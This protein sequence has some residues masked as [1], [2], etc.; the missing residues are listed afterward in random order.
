MS[1]GSGGS[2]LLQRS[3][4][5]SFDLTGCGDLVVTSFRSGALPTV[6]EEVE[7]A[8]LLVGLGRTFTADS[9]VTLDM[10]VRPLWQDDRSS[11]GFSSEEVDRDEDDDAACWPRPRPRR[12]ECPTALLAGLC[13]DLSGGL[14][15]ARAEGIR[16]P[17]LE[18]GHQLRLTA[19]WVDLDR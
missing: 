17:W 10:D 14:W 7:D 15:T 16:V 9:A 18:A 19:G 6:G 12:E 8:R 2:G 13:T 11:S 5:D 4:V 3:T 1:A